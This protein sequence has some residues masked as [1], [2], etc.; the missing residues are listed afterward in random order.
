MVSSMRF[1]LAALFLTVFAGP[2]LAADSAPVQ[3]AWDIL[4]AGVK[5]RSFNKR[6]DAIHAVGLLVGDSK[7]VAI[8]EKALEDPA[9]E[10]REAAATSLGE[11]HSSA[12][13]PKLELALKDKDPT[14]VLAAAH[15][16][17]Q[18]QDKQAYEIYY[19]ILLGERKAGPGLIAGQE[20]MFRDHK[21]LA[22]FAFEQG[23]EFNPFA[24]IGWG[25]I[26]TLHQ[27]DVSPVRAAAALILVDDPD[28]RSSQALVKTCSDKNWIVRVA[29]LDA[30]ARRGDATVLKD[31]EPHTADEKGRV[32]YT[33]AAA[34]IRL[35]GAPQEP[36]R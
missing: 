17:W 32:R 36:K 18:L 25:I 12:S 6:H 4:D 29:A 14:V 34:I 33:A 21:K 26:K 31:L 15:A 10:V 8:T 20:A 9:P 19:E 30:L 24:G 5:E 16:L 13:I 3:K 23:I 2:V 35:S 1:C 28:P 7:A 11:L 27:D 22:E